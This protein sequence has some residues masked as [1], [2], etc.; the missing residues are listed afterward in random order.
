MARR[1]VQAI[2][3]GLDADMLAQALLVNGANIF[4]ANYSPGFVADLLRRLADRIE[5]GENINA[6][7]NGGGTVH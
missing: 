2:A 1:V 5:A 4:L 3:K 6:T 7:G